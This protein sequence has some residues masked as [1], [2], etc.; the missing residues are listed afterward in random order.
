MK[1]GIPKEIKP[2]ESRVS[3]I[4]VGVQELVTEWHTVLVERGAGIESGYNDKEYEDAGAHIV[5]S[6]EELFGACDMIVKVKEPQPSEYNLIQPGQ[7]LFTF[8]HFA[9]SE[10]LT[11]AM[12][13]S[14]ALCIAYETL[15]SPDGLLPLLIPMSEIAGRM[16]PQ[17]G[18]SILERHNG[19]R[20]VLLGGVPGVRPAAVTILGGGV[21]GMNAALIA[22]GM[23]ASV[24][25]LDIN[26][27]RLRYLS[28]IMP[29]N[30]T[31]IHS[32]SETI[33]ECCA[34]SDLVI[35]A[36]LIPLN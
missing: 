23:G 22:S 18:A 17:C 36:V 5:N 35:G 3:V 25:I 9:S 20:G 7:I 32:N 6:N 21:A 15:E 1:I 31:T 28:E 27:S 29:T 2:Q 12:Q 4:P 16:A 11:R 34:V 26:I 8:F 14:R 13:K 30:V 10:E 33:A 19:G 24:Y